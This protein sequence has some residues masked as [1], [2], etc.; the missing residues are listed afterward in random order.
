MTR[1]WAIVCVYKCLCVFIA[2]MFCLDTDNY[3]NAHKY[4]ITFRCFYSTSCLFWSD[5]SWLARERS[6]MPKL[7]LCGFRVGCEPGG[8]AQ[9][10]PRKPCDIVT[11]MILPT[12]LAPS[13]ENNVLFLPPKIQRPQ[14]C[15]WSAAERSRRWG[16]MICVIYL[17]IFFYVRTMWLPV[18]N[19]Q[20]EVYLIFTFF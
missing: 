20:F 16:V 11:G 6:Q 14:P 12:T 15:P 13:E 19:D 10:H 5:H 8:Q 7:S 9:S 18:L 3:I 2:S 17:F 4:E 1:H